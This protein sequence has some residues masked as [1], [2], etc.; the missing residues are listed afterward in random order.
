MKTTKLSAEEIQAAE[1]AADDRRRSRS[2]GFVKRN[3]RDAAVKVL[4]NG[5]I[6]H[7]HVHK[8]QR[9]ESGDVLLDDGT[10]IKIT[11]YRGYNIPEDSFLLEFRNK[12]GETETHMFDLEEFRK[13]LRW[14]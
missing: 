5:V 9:E 1:K 12:H 2:Q 3:E 10:K 7:W 11:T 8:D 4:S 6:M 13:A 14:A